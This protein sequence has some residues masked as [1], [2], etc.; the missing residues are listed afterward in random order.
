MQQTP[1][2]RDSR[3]AATTSLCLHADMHLKRAAPDRTRQPDIP[4]ATTN[5]TIP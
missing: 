1:S 5:P 3:A 2:S 4:P